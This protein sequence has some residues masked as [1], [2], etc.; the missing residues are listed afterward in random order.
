[1]A[2][3]GIEADHYEILGDALSQKVQQGLAGGVNALYPDLFR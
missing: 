3:D 2:I 1:M